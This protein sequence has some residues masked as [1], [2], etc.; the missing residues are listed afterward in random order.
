M[1]VQACINGARPS[2]FHPTLPLTI[3]AMAHDSAACIA[4]GAA[5][6]YPYVLFL[7]PECGDIFDQI[8][9]ACDDRTGEPLFEVACNRLDA[10][11]GARVQGR[12][13]EK[14]PC[15]AI[16]FERT[17]YHLYQRVHTMW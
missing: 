3:H 2:N 11:C 10:F 15:R 16:D 8:L 9:P 12:K 17:L 4:A 5:E 6:K 13:V 7:F 1:I 14:D